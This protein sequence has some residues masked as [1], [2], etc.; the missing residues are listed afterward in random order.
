MMGAGLASRDA[1]VHSAAGTADAVPSHRAVLD[2]IRAG[3]AGAAE[4]AMRA[5]L[6]QSWRD[7]D[8]V[9][10]EHRVNV[11]TERGDRG[12]EQE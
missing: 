2:A 12:R 9:R 6:L 11:R 7:L 1:L 4:E 3:D 5:L 10:G 8:R